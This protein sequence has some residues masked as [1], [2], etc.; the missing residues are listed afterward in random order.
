MFSG[1]HFETGQSVTKGQGFPIPTKSLSCGLAL[2]EDL[3]TEEREILE[4][5][6]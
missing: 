6:C 2:I 1:F 5:R 3:I 4:L